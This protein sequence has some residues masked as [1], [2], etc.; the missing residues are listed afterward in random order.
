MKI[1]KVIYQA[2][3]GYTGGPGGGGIGVGLLFYNGKDNLVLRVQGTIRYPSYQT[4]NVKNYGGYCPEPGYFTLWQG[5]IKATSCLIKV[6]DVDLPQG[7]DIIITADG[8][9]KVV[10]F[11]ALDGKPQ[12][13]EA[14][15][16]LWHEKPTGIAIIAVVL[17]VAIILITK[18]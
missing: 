6:Y 18:K 9:D 12:E 10:H 8:K 11:P 3:P 4:E 2:P 7:V 1:T 13:Q 16:L 14:D 5:E 17:V 15:L